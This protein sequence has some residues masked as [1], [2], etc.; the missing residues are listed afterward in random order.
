MRKCT[1]IGLTA[2]P[3]LACLVG[4]AV[5]GQETGPPAS[6]EDD[7]RIIY[8]ELGD[9]RPS[10]IT[11]EMLL[12]EKPVRVARPFLKSYRIEKT[13]IPHEFSAPPVTR[14]QLNPGGKMGAVDSWLIL[15]DGKKSPVSRGIYRI[16][17]GFLFECDPS[18]HDG[19]RPQRF[20]AGGDVLISIIRNGVFK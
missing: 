11:N 13:E 18:K 5:R 6:I 15:E 7:W 12:A 9:N 20:K 4:V 2:P 17:D 19:V 3:L 8:L 1:F 10:T 16:K 14:I